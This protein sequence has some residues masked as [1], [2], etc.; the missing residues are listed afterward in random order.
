MSREDVKITLEA[1]RVMAGYTQAE[2][3]RQLG[4]APSTLASWENNSTKLSYLEANRLAKLYG[5]EPDLLFFGKRNEFIK[6][7][8][9]KR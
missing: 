2:A 5:I 4:I 1:A 7:I 9:E 6:T 8:R 3:A